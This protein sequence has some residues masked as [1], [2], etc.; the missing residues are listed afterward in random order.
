MIGYGATLY[1]VGISSH[2]VASDVETGLRARYWVV[3]SLPVMSLSD[4]WCWQPSGIIRTNRAEQQRSTPEMLPLTHHPPPTLQQS[5]AVSLYLILL[6]RVELTFDH[7]GLSYGYFYSF[8][9]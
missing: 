4:G 1:R 9:K 7:I 3:F 2:P 6:C 8:S 5:Q